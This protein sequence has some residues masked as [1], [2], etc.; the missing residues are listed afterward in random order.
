MTKPSAL[1]KVR[2][3]RK[4]TLPDVARIEVVDLFCGA[5]GLSCGLKKAGV[6]VVAGID[7]DATCKYPYEANHPGAKFL[8]QDVTTLTGADLKALWSPTSVRLLAGC[9][10]CQ[11]FSSYANTKVAAENDK[12]GLLYQFGRLVAETKPD[13]VTMENV[14]GL[15]AQAPF[16]AFLRILK[17]AG[18]NIQYAV[19]NAA[20]YGAPQQRKRLV[21]LAS[22]LGRVQMPAATHP[23]SARWV[24][25]RDAVGALPAIDD[26]E[27]ST[28]DPLHRA[29]A[30]S[31]LNQ[32]RVRAS[33]PGGTWRDWPADLVAECHRKPSGQHSA[34]VYG[35]MEWD[36]PAPT[37]TTLCIGYGNGRFGHPQQH[38]G[39]SLREAAIF[40]SFPPS[41]KFV[42]PGS[43]VLAKRLAR[44][45][46]NAVPPKLG[47]AVGRALQAA[48]RSPAGTADA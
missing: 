34:G 4:P 22:L 35:R 33:R 36:K 27:V 20:D 8:L 14:P 31:P 10:P 21:L 2:N 39:I 32:Q 48:V 44:L 45:I 40:Q 24:T 46:G 37:M 38:R 1:P 17:A 42:K 5:G 23:G 41:Y 16:K 15:A 47:E 25:V 28:Q 3:P 9:A 18:Y 29:S 12:W 6:R 13:L 11:P 30:L 19:L 7:V 26:G 43:P